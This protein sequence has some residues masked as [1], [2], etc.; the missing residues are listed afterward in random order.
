MKVKK[1]KLAFYLKIVLCSL[2]IAIWAIWLTNL[3]ETSTRKSKTENQKSI[4]TLQTPSPNIKL[5]KE[6][7][8]LKKEKT[9]TLKKIKENDL[10][11]LANIIPKNTQ[12]EKKLRA[13]KEEP[14]LM[15]VNIAEASR[16]ALLKAKSHEKNNKETLDITPLRKELH[17]KAEQKKPV[18]QIINESSVGVNLLESWL[19]KYLIED[20]KIN[21]EQI[22]NRLELIGLVN[23]LNGQ[24]A[25]IIKNKTSN[26][27]NILK[28]GEEYQGLKI[29]EINKNENKI[30]LGNQTLNTTF[31]KQIT[32]SN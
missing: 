14:A 23:N 21:L 6:E 17:T 24:T 22:V 18:L 26:K 2:A 19:P 13:K 15:L 3:P 12:E 11:K 10:P 5:P 16:N 9:I 20:K 28:V 29:I 30:I 4:L 31:T 25:A 27:I 32:S 7:K 8:K 1:K